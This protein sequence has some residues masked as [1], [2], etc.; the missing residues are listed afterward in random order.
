[1]TMIRQGWAVAVLL[2]LAHATAGAADAADIQAPNDMIEDAAKLLDEKLDGRKD[3]LAADNQA[4][5]ALIDEILL[6]RFDRRYA[7]QLVLG[8]H[9][10]NASAEQQEAF[11]DAFY[12]SLL[13]RYADGILKFEMNKVDILPYRADPTK[14]RTMVKTRVKL[15]DGTDVPVNYGLVKRSEGWLIFDVVI[16]GISYVRNYRAE[17]NSEIQRSSLDAVIERLQSENSNGAAKAS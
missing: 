7:A 13:R 4:L 12:G 9:W 2:L 1:M 5:Y 3:E 8:R 17:L 6:P 14:S 11:I 15:D 10:R 16:E